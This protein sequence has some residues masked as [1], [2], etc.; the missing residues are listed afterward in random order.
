LSRGLSQLD[1]ARRTK[2]GEEKAIALLYLCRP[3]EKGKKKGKAV[4]TLR[5]R[6]GDFQKKKKEQMKYHSRAALPGEEEREGGGKKLVLT[7]PPAPPGPKKRGKTGS[8]E[9]EGNATFLVTTRKNEGKGRKEVGDI[10]RPCAR[11]SMGPRKA[12]K[13]EREGREPFCACAIEEKKKRGH[14]MLLFV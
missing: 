8:R 6:K 3:K 10:A 13:R 12:K 4:D 11:A 9:K 2:R 5:V 7:A 14:Y 1:G